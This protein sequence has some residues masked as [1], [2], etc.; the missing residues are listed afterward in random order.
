MTS[1]E[2]SAPDNVVSAATIAGEVIRKILKPG[3]DDE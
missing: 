1:V 3:D 2:M